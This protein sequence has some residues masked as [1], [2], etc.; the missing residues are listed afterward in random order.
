M[1]TWTNW[2]GNVTCHPTLVACAS[3]RDVARAVVDA[4]AAGR[5]VRV[6]GTGHSF[7]PL[8]ATDDVLLDL[9]ALAGL[10]GADPDAR[11]VEVWAGTRLRALGELLAGLGLAQ[12]NLGDV[13][14]QTL[15]GALSTGTHGTGATL[16]GLASQVVALTLVTAGGETLRLDAAADPAGFAAARVGLGALGVITRVRLRCVKAFHLRET[17]RKLTLDACLADLARLTAAHRRFEFFWLPYADQ[18]QAK[19]L[20]E[21][22]E[23]VSGQGFAKAFT[24]VVLENGALGL[25]SELARA[26]PVASPLVNQLLAAGI[27]E[28]REVERSNRMF[29]TPRF[30]RFVEMEYALPVEALVPVIGAMRA[31]IARERFAVSFPIEVRFGAPEDASLSPAHGRATAYVAVH[32]YKGMPHA[33]YFQAMEAIFRDA[34]GRPHWGKLHTQ[35][36]AELA[37]RYPRWAEFQAVR[38]RLDP[39]GRFSNAHLERVLGPHGA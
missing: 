27:G 16:G 23:P 30:V 33:P 38:R 35:D 37:G 20:D 18:V 2:A 15:A 3:E 11:E 10:I 17:K 14:V 32:M 9:T 28:S 19:T 5:R 26:V 7:T 4:A 22:D 13:D 31:A 36:A 39:D 1:T 29:A 21:T 6:A 12:E 8:V 34:D 24:D 25:L